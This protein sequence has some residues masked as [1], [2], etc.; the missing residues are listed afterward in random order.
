[1]YRSSLHEFWRNKRV[2]ISGHTGFKGS[3]LSLWL[4]FLGADLYGVALKPVGSKSTYSVAR[5][6][7]GMQSYIQNINNFRSLYRITELIQPEIVFHLAAQ[8][9][10]ASLTQ[11]QEKHTRPM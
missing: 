3:W 9:L 11:I 1:M 2:L 6:S 7:D 5:V 8:R 10:Y 4:Q